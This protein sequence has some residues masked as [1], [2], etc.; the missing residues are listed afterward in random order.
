M[1]RD[2]LKRFMLTHFRHI[3]IW[4][5]LHIYVLHTYH[6]HN[7]VLHIHVLHTYQMYQRPKET[8]IYH[9]RCIPTKKPIYMENDLQKRPKYQW[10][11]KEIKICNKSPISTKWGLYT[12][13]L[14]HKRDPHVSGSQKKSKY[15]NRALYSRNGTYI[16]EKWPTKETRISADHPHAYTHTH[17][18]TYIY[19]YTHTYAHLHLSIATVSEKPKWVSFV[20]VCM[21]VCVC[22]H[23]CVCLCVFL[24]VCVCVRVCVCVTTRVY[25]IGSP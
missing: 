20:R 3:S 22:V 7:H 1:R 13:K 11:K 14:T 19:T 16:D 5:V 2:P 8:K 18:H 4:Y 15:V 25:I 17:T 6:I 21:C 10:I 9:K 12:W 24:C 23:V